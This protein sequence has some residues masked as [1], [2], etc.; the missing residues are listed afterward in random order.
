MPTLRRAQ[1]ARGMT[2]IDIIVGT[3]LM[4]LVFLGIAGA[5]RLSLE[6]VGS[7]RAKTSALAILNERIEGIRAL[8][9]QSIGTVGG[10]PS[11]TI[12]QI[13]STSLNGVSF[14]IRT[15]IQYVD[16][17]QDG[18]D[19][20]DEN[21]VTADYKKVK[22]E[23]SWM[24]RG[25]PRAM[26]LTTT[27]SPQGIE[28]LDSGGTLRVQVF[29]ALAA[30]VQGAQ[31]RIVNSVTNPAIDVTALSNA[32]GIVSFPGS[33]EASD[34]EITVS[35][36]G[37]STAQTYGTTAENPNPSPAHVTVVEAQTSTIS[38]SVDRTGSIRIYSFSPIEGGTWSDSFPDAGNIAEAV[39]TEVSSDLL[40]L[41]GGAGSYSLSGSVRSNGVSQTYLADWNEATWSTEVPLGTDVRVQVFFS[42]LNGY[43]LVPEEVLPGNAAGF[44]LS[45]LDLSSVP[46]GTYG[47]LALGAL[48]TTTDPALTPSID[49]WGIS[50]NSGPTPLPNVPFD[51]VGTTKTIGT[52]TDGS[53]IYKYEQSFATTAFGEWLLDPLEWDIYSF[54]TTG[55]FDIY[56]LCPSSLSLDPAEA[57]EVTLLAVPE[58]EDTLR[59][60]VADVS[61][62]PIPDALVSVVGAGETLTSVCGQAFFDVDAGTYSVS[63]SK[64]GYQSSVVDVQVSGDTV[65]SV[66]LTP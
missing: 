33:P 59:I 21:G 42:D 29:D 45:P 14:S 61:G 63:V 8:Q 32:N 39:N 3:S 53:P 9:Y 64:S 43:S 57:L 56:E 58:A 20:D 25:S 4:L 49:T 27:I 44:T 22:V 55:S 12:P 16:A 6:L 11:G 31:V 60:I 5:F 2:F 28:Q 48:L 18:L 17:P 66:S 52:A 65:H 7:A 10:I 37:Y 30:P 38:F 51:I 54:D 26:S 34:Y 36:T 41:S 19:A 47:T 13:E 35:K 24:F 1:G 50:Y 23:A 40:V 46:I 15:L 62:V